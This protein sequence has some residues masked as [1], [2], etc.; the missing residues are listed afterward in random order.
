MLF[1]LLSFLEIDLVKR[2]FH[3]CAQYARLCIAIIDLFAQA[4][5]LAQLSAISKVDGTACTKSD[6]LE[7][8]CSVFPVSVSR[9]V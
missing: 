6:G 4:L 5:R 3:D 7:S 9:R 2:P 8:R 1:A